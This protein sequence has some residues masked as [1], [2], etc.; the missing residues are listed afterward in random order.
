M[1]SQT[2]LVNDPHPGAAFSLG[3]S[4]STRNNVRRADSNSPRRSNCHCGLQLEPTPNTA[5]SFLGS[6]ATDSLG[7]KI[8]DDRKCCGLKVRAL[9]CVVMGQYATLAHRTVK[10]Y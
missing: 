10:A 3:L 4:T 7:P 1:R 6:F 8:A 9:V 5:R 2:P